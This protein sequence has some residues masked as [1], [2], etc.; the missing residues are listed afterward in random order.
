MF[1]K[2]K[3]PEPVDELSLGTDDQREHFRVSLPPR[4]PVQLELAGHSY[5]VRDLSAGGLSFLADDRHVGETLDGLMLLPEPAAPI[6]MKLSIVRI[7]AD[8]ICHGHYAAMA[9]G[10]QEQIHRLVLEVQKF[11]IRSTREHKSISDDML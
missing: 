9:A 1:W 2:R 11:Q 7:D 3:R 6:R 5:A 10:D 8:G 4:M